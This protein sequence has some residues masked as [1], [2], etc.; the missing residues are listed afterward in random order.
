MGK[1][2]AMVAWP[3]PTNISELRGFLGLIEY[4]RKFVKNYGII[5]RPLTDLLKQGQFGWNDEVEAAFLALK[6]AMTTT[7]TLAIP[8]FDDSFTIE[9]DTS[10]DGIGAVLSQQGK[11]IAF[12]SRALGISKRS[13]SV[14]AKEMLVIVEAI[15]IWQPYLEQRITTPNQ[16]QWVAKLLGYDYEIQY[17][18]G[19]ENTAADA[20]SRKPTSPIIN[21][22]FVPQVHI[23]DEI[24]EATR[25]DEYTIK[26]SRTAQ[27]QPGGSYKLRDGLIFYKTRVV[28]PRVSEIR[29]KLLAKFHDSKLAGQ[30][31]V[32]RTYKRLAQH[33]Y[34]PNM[35]KEVQDYVS[36]CAICQKT[37]SEALAP[38]GLLQP[39][40]IPCQVWDDITLDFIEGLSMSHGKDTILVVVDRLTKYAHFMSLTHPFTARVVA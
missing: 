10:G 1:I 9:A 30:S 23:W 6:Q 36:T 25:G 12:M 18:P 15:R 19:R 40:P 28:V 5:A 33:F 27:D 2:E 34:L 26:L 22:L 38:A 31:G 24:Q 8:N 13:W 7:P 35:Y 3:R 11:P 17:R 14:Y 16:Q 29:K 20:L 37:K 21:N 39:L 4:Y 32:L